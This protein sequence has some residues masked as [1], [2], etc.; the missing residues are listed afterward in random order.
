MDR[1]TRLLASS[2]VLLRPVFRAWFRARTKGLQTWCYPHGESVVGVPGPEPARIL[3]L[4]DGPAAG[5]GVLTQQLGVAGHLARHLAE[6]MAR[7]VVVTVE[8]WPAA[9]AE[10]TLERLPHI[11]LDGYDGIVVMLATSDALRL[12]SR[13][14]WSRSMAGLLRTLPGSDTRAVF[15]TTTASVRLARTLP[16]FAR[17]VAGR[18]AQVLD[19]ETRRICAETTTTLIPLDAVNELSQRTYATWG[20]RI[21]AVVVADLHPNG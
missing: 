15:V 8:A 19:A 6:S 10:S 5:Y 20:R 9:S 14:S 16:P 12:T 11:D 1:Y 4:G 21:A 18:H 7:G 17:R 2:H 3:L 13:R